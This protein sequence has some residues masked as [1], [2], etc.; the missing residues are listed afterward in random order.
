MAHRK[1]F[2]LLDIYFPFFSCLYSYLRQKILIEIKKKKSPKKL[3][4]LNTAKRTQIML[5]ANK[6]YYLILKIL[7]V[8]LCNSK[9]KYR[10]KPNYEKNLIFQYIQIPP[11]SSANKIQSLKIYIKLCSLETKF[12]VRFCMMLF[13]L[14]NIF[15]IYL[16]L[17]KF[18]NFSLKKL[19]VLLILR[20]V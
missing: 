10:K 11:F 1:Q 6:K 7:F 5:L 8:Y 9:Q 14:R 3:I 4:Y 20:G 18:N 15:F 16:H 13:F 17:I 12:F 2:V 19:N